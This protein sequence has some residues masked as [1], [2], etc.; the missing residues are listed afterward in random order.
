LP[1]DWLWDESWSDRQER[2]AGFDQQAVA[3][4]F[5]WVF[6]CNGLGRTL[7]E[8]LVRKGYGRVGICDDDIVEVTNLNRTLWRHEAVGK[9]KAVQALEELAEIAP[10]RTELIAYVG[11]LQEVVAS[12]LINGASAC[13]IGIDNDRGRAEAAKALWSLKI[14]ATF[15]SISADTFTYEVFIQEAAGP[16]WACLYPERYKDGLENLV[17]NPCS[18][19]PSVADPCLA[20]IGLCS[21]ALD[22]LL[23]GRPRYWNFRQGHLHGEIPETIKQ[24]PKS[25][26]CDLCIKLK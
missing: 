23:I 3:D 19:T 18:K 1:K 20:A 12:P 10:S 17:G 9:F 21:Y 8:F 15:Y 7:A 24:V 2:I 14:P 5:V 4:A 16:C 25:F 26:F 22:S 13:L 6:G 11:K